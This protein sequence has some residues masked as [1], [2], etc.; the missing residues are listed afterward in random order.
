MAEIYYT[1][2]RGATGCINEVPGPQVDEYLI[3]LVKR[4]PQ[5]HN[6]LFLVV[7]GGSLFFR[8]VKDEKVIIPTNWIKRT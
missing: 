1:T 4:K 6:F 2:P 7:S 5:Y 8:I 3:D